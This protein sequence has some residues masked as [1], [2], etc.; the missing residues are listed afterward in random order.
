M[1]RALNGS[2]GCSLAPCRHFARAIEELDS[3]LRVLKGNT[4]GSKPLDV[5]GEALGMSP[6]HLRAYRRFARN[7]TDAHEATLEQLQLTW[8]RVHQLLQ[9]KRYVN[10]SGTISA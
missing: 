4:Y 8:S 9:V 2:S 1:R 5:L 6:A 7:F 3:K 10:A